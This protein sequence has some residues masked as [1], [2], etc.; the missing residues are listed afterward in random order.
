MPDAVNPLAA[1]FQ[2]ALPPPPPPPEPQSWWEDTIG[3]PVADLNVIFKQAEVD[4]PLR[5]AVVAYRRMV[6]NRIYARASRARSKADA[7]EPLTDEDTLALLQM[8][9]RNLQAQIARA[10]K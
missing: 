5:D 9:V 6:N 7:G 4:R 10:G 8:R 1:A 3:V 2:P